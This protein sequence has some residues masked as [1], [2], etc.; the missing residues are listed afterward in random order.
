[1]TGEAIPGYE[2]QHKAFELGITAAVEALKKG[3][4]TPYDISKPII[5][6]PAM[7]VFSVPDREGYLVFIPDEEKK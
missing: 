3:A 5:D 7:L 4:L 1:M 2:K 6:D